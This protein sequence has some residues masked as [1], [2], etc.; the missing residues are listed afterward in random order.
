MTIVSVSI[1]AKLQAGIIRV[2]HLAEQLSDESAYPLDDV[3][4]GDM[5]AMMA[6]V[7]QFK[8]QMQNFPDFS[9]QTPQQLTT[10]RHDL[11][12]HLNL[13]GG[14]AYVF[15]RGLGG[16]MPADK[17][18]IAAQIHRLSKSLITIVNKIA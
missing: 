14:F 16:Q 9:T 5:Q 1:H 8:A 10:L 3:Q 12:N 18:E 13:I 17:M 7:N 15:T 6:G 4:R 2:A 11:R